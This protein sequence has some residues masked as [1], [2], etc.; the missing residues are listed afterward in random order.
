MKIT[1][2]TSRIIDIPTVRAHKLAFGAVRTQTYVIV[3]IVLDDGTIGFGEAATIGGA[4]WSEESPESIRHIVDDYLA[5]AILGTDPR[6]FERQ[7]ELFERL[8]KGNRFAK[9]AVEMAMIDAVSRAVG[10][11]AWQLLGGKLHDR[12]PLAWTLATGN[13]ELDIAEAERKLA[14]GKHRLFK[15]KI[16][17]GRPEDDVA[18]VAAIARSLGDRAEIRVDVNQAW[19]WLAAR[20]WVPAL[21]DA[22]VAMAEQPVARWQTELL[23]ELCARESGPAI[24]ADESVCSP[25]DALTLAASRAAHVFSLKVTKHGGLVNTRKVAA[26]AEAAGIACYGGTMLETSLGSAA[27]AHVFCGIP[28]LTAGCELFGPM[29]LVED[30]VTEPLRAKDFCLEMPGGP[31]FGVEVD[32]EK[33]DAFDRDR[34]EHRPIRVDLGAA[35][36]TQTATADTTETPEEN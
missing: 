13:P 31:G 27:S 34:R 6:H 4:S 22:G 30:I 5:P 24:M 15:I 16:G 3:E 7:L 23:R 19:D 28:G 35:P 32:R 10:L 11:P 29:L 33:L 25:Q 9:A 20:R 26:V 1:R 14:E 21:G 2:C 8:C 12:L 18:R 17:S 36:R